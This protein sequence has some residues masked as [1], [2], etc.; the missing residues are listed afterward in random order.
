MS[1][2]EWIALITPTMGIVGVIYA[3]VIKLAR[4]ADS[5]ERITESLVGLVSKVDAHEARIG[6]LEQR[7]PGRHAARVI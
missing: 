7:S 1:S 5:L 2:G 3:A 4:M 6:A